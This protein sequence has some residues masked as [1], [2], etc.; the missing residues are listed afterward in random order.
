MINSGF[1]I[2]N[3][4]DYPIQ[5]K[6]LIIHETCVDS[7]FADPTQAVVRQQNALAKTHSRRPLRHR[8]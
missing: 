6:K 2:L 7:H 1:K 4:Q 5:Q 3:F 8:R